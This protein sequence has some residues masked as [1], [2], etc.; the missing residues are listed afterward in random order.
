MQRKGI[1]PS[2]PQQ[3]LM[4]SALSRPGCLFKEHWL[5]R[6]KPP[7][8]V[9][10]THTTSSQPGLSAAHSPACSA[11]KPNKGAFL[12]QEVGEHGPAEQESCQESGDPEN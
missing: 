4:G 7:A 8:A 9:T 5:T 10:H 6:L 12:A 2:Q 11:D 1:L 3:M